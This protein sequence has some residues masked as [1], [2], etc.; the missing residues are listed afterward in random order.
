[1]L[2]RLAAQ[3]AVMLLRAA[4][5]TLLVA[6]VATLPAEAGAT[7]IGNLTSSLSNARTGQPVRALFFTRL[8]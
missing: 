5:A 8:K 2:V 7:D 1:V 6:A 4:A 3:A